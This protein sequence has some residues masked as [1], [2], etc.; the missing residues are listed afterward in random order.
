MS[1]RRRAE[2]TAGGRHG[3]RGR[4]RNGSTTAC[5]SRIFPNLQP[6]PVVFDLEFRQIV[7]ANEIENL[8]QLVE[9]QS[10]VRSRIQY[11]DELRRR[12]VSTSTPSSVTSTS[13]SIRTPP[14]P[15]RYAPGSIVNTMPAATGS[16]SRIDVRP[17]SRDPRLFVNLDAKAMARAVAERL[18]QSRAR[19]RVAR[20][21]VDREARPPR[22]DRRDRR[23][24]APSQTA[25]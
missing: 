8:L 7:L 23:D 17:P 19:Q 25:S 24:R 4:R 22:A 5:P 12:V 18:A 9:V 1:G 3:R 16:S 2:C 14:Q 10:D 11:F 6:Q 21:R 20:R 15:G 13:S